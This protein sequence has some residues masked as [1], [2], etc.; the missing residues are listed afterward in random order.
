MLPLTVFIVNCEFVRATPGRSVSLAIGMH[1][2]TEK[3]G[4]ADP[5]RSLIIEWTAQLPATRRSP[6]SR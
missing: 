3:I 5:A 4:P 1:G 2:K 6:T